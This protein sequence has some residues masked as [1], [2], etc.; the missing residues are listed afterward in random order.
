M[1]LRPGSWPSI[2]AI[3]LFGI[4]SSAGFGKMVPILPDIKLAFGVSSA[5]AGLVMSVLAVMGAVGALPAGTI[6]N[7]L[8]DKPVLAGCALL[9]IVANLAAWIAPNI[10]WLIASRA[11]DGV[12]CI[13]FAV[14]GLMLLMRTTEGRRRT[15]ALTLWATSIPIGFQ[16]GV[17]NASSVAGGEHWRWVFLGTAVLQAV[18]FLLALSFPPHIADEKPESFRQSFSVIFAPKPLR[19]GLAF[20]VLAVL[21][22]GTA[23]IIPLYFKTAFGLPIAMTAMF[24][25]L[26]TFPDSCGSFITGYLLNRG[27]RS[28]LVGAIGTVALIAGGAIYMFP[29]SG[30]KLAIIGMLIFQFSTGCFTALMMAML[31]HVRGTHS[32]SSTSGIF[33][34]LSF[35]G[36]VIA[37]PLILTTQDAFGWYGVLAYIA[38]TA[39]LI[40]LLVPISGSLPGTS[41]AAA[42]NRETV[43]I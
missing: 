2:F 5:T 18:A 36:L 14:A 6:I 34:Q 29:Q 42:E 4:L 23:T 12:T 13:A 40:L 39:I 37:T 19:L 27:W 33:N 3:Y 38:V 15:T 30:W 16:F 17:I 8:G 24:S 28:L 26:S 43:V 1:R 7:R 11:L 10:G 25:S 21:Q 31:P 20:G 32:A 35:V 41:K 22:S 9:S